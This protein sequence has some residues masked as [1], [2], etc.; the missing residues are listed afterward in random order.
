MAH[1]SNLAE[2]LLSQKDRIDFQVTEYTWVEDFAPDYN[3]FGVTINGNIIGRAMD[4]N[5]EMALNKAIAEAIER[6]TC[7]HNGL[8][9]STGVAAHPNRK[10]AI[11]NA[12]RELIER[13]AFDIHFSQGKPFKKIEARTAEAQRA[14]LAFET[15]G[16]QYS[17]FELVSPP[18]FTVIC[19]VAFGEK[20]QRPF[21]GLYGFGCHEDRLQ[22]ERSALFESLRNAAYYTRDENIQSLS[23]A[24][25]QRI[26]SP[27]AFDRLR[28]ALNI[29]YHRQVSFL[30]RD[31][32]KCA[33]EFPDLNFDEAE[34][35]KPTE[36]FDAPLSVVRITSDYQFLSGMNSFPSFMD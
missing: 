23:V 32:E 18:E 22:A 24:E 36:F 21:G 6:A 9:K 12:R 29:A 19:A 25:F 17:F 5:A 16:I 1:Q 34:L 33:D 35:R 8:T 2:W 11:E 3:D 4:Q 26:A 15:L 10:I 20:Y 13:I 30:F 28:L 7:V 31:G 27:K 14:A